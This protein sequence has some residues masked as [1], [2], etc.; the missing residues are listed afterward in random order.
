MGIN[1]QKIDEII[2]KAIGRLILE[3]LSIS[4]D[5]VQCTD[6]VLG[7]FIEL[8][9]SA[10]SPDS[11]LKRRYIKENG[12][13]IELWEYT[14]KLK[15][16]KAI[17][18]LIPTANKFYCTFIFFDSMEDYDE[19]YDMVAAECKVDAD[20][21][22]SFF[23]PIV[24][25]II[26]KHDFRTNLIHEVEHLFQYSKGQIAPYRKLKTIAQDNIRNDD[27]LVSNFGYLL[28]YI[29]PMETNAY[30]NEIYSQLKDMFAEN[31]NDI[32]KCKSYQDYLTVVKLIDYFRT[33]SNEEMI[34][35]LAPYKISLSKFWKYVNEQNAY[36][37]NRL[38]KVVARYFAE[39]Q[40]IQETYRRM[41]ARNYDECMGI[42]SKRKPKRFLSM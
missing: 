14:Y 15:A 34:N 10:A 39:R 25:G 2:K 7:K 8:Y 35:L 22:I 16:D 28:Y 20:N 42:E 26:Q 13:E 21:S 29:D 41:K 37:Q 36:F 11:A 40:Q 18:S 24:N 30:V 12:Q 19:L 6:Y 9:N 27:V 5:V 3:K 1:Q 31:V 33:L 38:R 23:G 4:N 17:H 32:Y